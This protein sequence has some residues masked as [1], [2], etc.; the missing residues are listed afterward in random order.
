MLYFSLFFKIISGELQVSTWGCPWERGHLAR[1]FTRQCRHA[2]AEYTVPHAG[3]TPAL[4]VV[5]FP[6][7]QIAG[8]SL[9]LYACADGIIASPEK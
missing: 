4:Q 3:G 6:F 8:F 5:S 7:Y 1:C 9:C 2:R